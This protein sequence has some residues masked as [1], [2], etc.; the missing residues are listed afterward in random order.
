MP[1]AAAVRQEL[2]DLGLEDSIPLPEAV[3]TARSL[4]CEHPE[5]DVR[6]AVTE[7]TRQGHFR[8]W[9]GPWAREDEHIEVPAHELELLLQDLRW[10]RFRLEEPDEERLYFV[11]VENILPGF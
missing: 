8:W 3:A 5:H 7:L 4:G 6:E 11:N 10:Y 9:R 1:D 2:L